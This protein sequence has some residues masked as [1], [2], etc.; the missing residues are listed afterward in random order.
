LAGLGKYTAQGSAFLVMMILGGAV[1]PPLQGKV[2]D[3]YGVQLSYLVGIVCFM[4]L[5]G[6]GII[7]KGILRKQNIELE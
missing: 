5:V 1:I 4:F 7:V 6:Y 3:I 2:V